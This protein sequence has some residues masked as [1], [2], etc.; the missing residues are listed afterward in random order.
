[1]LAVIFPV[2]II[3]CNANENVAVTILPLLCLCVWFRKR[4]KIAVPLWM[5]GGIIGTVIGSAVLLGAPGVAER[6]SF[7]SHPPLNIFRNTVTL[8]AHLLHS[9]SGLF[10]MTVACNVLAF[11]FLEKKQKETLCFYW[12]AAAGSAGAMIFSPYIPGRALFGCFIFLLCIWGKCF[13]ALPYNMVKLKRL[14]VICI[15]SMA[16]FEGLYALRDVNFTFK[17]CEVRMQ[18]MRKAQKQ[19]RSENWEFRPIVGMSPYNALFK[20]DIFRE[21]PEHFLN[22]YYS[23]KYNQKSVKLTAV[24]AIQGMNNMLFPGEEKK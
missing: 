11:R 13:H 3:A 18:C 16:F 6:I 19:G 15:T 24:P 20:T 8:L 2:S 12:L 7:E 1:M 4:S 10:V 17:M 21:D 9:I 5:W 14:F 22:R 23:K